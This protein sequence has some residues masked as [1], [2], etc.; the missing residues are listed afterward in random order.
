MMMSGTSV[1]C[2]H[3]DG[4]THHNQVRDPTT[5]SSSEW[6]CIRCGSRRSMETN[7]ERDDH[8]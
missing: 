8:T 6:E 5:F 4:Y 7:D 2:E 3:C 1:Y